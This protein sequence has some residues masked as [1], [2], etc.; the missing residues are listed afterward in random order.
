M[1]LEDVK[2][3]HVGSTL[4]LVDL[5]DETHIVLSTTDALRL[6]DFIDEH[7]SPYVADE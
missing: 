7:F 6:R 4:E 2:V 5:E 3:N 1:K